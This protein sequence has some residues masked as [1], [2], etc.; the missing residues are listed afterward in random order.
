[1]AVGFNAIPSLLTSH[2]AVYAEAGASSSCF[3]INKYTIVHLIFL[4]V[5]CYYNPLVTWQSN[6]K[7]G[8]HYG[9][10]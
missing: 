6:K 2:C 7:Q 3:L 5:K 1:M 9:I 8:L 4:M 10:L